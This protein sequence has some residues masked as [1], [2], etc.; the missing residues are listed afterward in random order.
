MVLMVPQVAS[1]LLDLK[2]KG[3]LMGLF[4]KIPALKKSNA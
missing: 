2:L 1:P 4:L 3:H